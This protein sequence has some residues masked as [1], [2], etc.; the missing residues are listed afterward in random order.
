[1]CCLTHVCFSQRV[2]NVRAQ[3]KGNLVAITYDLQGTISGQLYEIQVFSSHNNMAGLL[4]YV[5]G[6]VGTNQKPGRNKKIEWGAKNELSN[7]EGDIT[8]EIRATLT[9]SPMR[10]TNPQGA[11]VYKRGNNYKMSWLGAIANENLQLELYRDSTRKFEIV[12]V[13]N[14][15]SYIWDI[16]QHVEPGKNYRLK[17]SSVD[18]PSNFSF[19][20]PFTIKRKTSTILKAL[21]VGVA[22]GVAYI[23]FSTGKNTEGPVEEDLPLPPPP[24]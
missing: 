17:I 13:E 16:P 12:R 7:F 21:P 24:E 2:T 8:L 1:M 10:F 5:R 19:S 11:T 18:K 6:E 14:K 15:G 3:A 4:T 20:S 9:F 22:A 23:L